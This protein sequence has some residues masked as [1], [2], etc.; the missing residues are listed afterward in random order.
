MGFLPSKII[1]DE[2]KQL[3]SKDKNFYGNIMVDRIT[4]NL[5]DLS[6]EDFEVDGRSN[7]PV[8][9]TDLLFQITLHVRK[10]SW[11]LEDFKQ[12]F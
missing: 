10:Q 4:F 7:S 12:Y 11:F 2:S 1:P 9:E 3:L 8:P 6:D 5:N